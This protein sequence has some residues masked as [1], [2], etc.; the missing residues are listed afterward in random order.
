MLA[1]IKMFAVVFLVTYML[2]AFLAVSAYCLIVAFQKN[3][4]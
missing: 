2:L 4:K 3:K 1:F